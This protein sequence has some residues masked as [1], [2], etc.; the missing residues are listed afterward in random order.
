MEKP[1][2]LLNRCALEKL[3]K[4]GNNTAVGHAFERA[5][6]KVNLSKS[7]FGSITTEKKPL[8]LDLTN[9]NWLQNNNLLKGMNTTSTNAS[10]R[11]PCLSP[12]RDSDLDLTFI[13]GTQIHGG[14]HVS[15]NDHKIRLSVSKDK[16]LKPPYSFSSLI[17]M[18]IED[19][20]TKKLPVKDIYNW[21]T[22]RFPYFQNAPLGW[23]NSV[24]HNLSLNKC[25]MKVDKDKGQAMGKGSLW[26]VDPEYRP[27]LLQALRKTPSFHPY[28]QWTTPPPSPQSSNGS[29]PKSLESR[30]LQSINRSGRRTPNVDPEAE[31]EAAATMCMMGGA[32]SDVKGST[33]SNSAKRKKQPATYKGSF[34]DLL[35]VAKSLDKAQKGKR[36][37]C[38]DRVSPS[39][40]MD[41]E[42]EFDHCSDSEDENNDA[43]ETLIKNDGLEDSGYGEKLS[44]TSDKNDGDIV[45]ADALLELASKACAMQPLS[46]ASSEASD[47]S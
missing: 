46:V 23:K 30:V 31:A 11:A 42:Y 34:S 14:G 24:R 37:R 12:P 41:S 2:T 3:G 20:P 33:H 32:S 19:A 18:A 28:S 47:S 4:S 45:G 5:K 13:P 39:S 35:S 36:K 26:C 27:N 17:F 29:T 21:I 16:P 10:A 1:H 7:C 38:A 8:D 40:S 22:E 43:M 6:I 25:F 15:K 9:L 44:K